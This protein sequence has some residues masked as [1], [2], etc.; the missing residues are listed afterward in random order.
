[1]NKHDKPV[2]SIRARLND[3]TLTDRIEPTMFK[4]P[5][6]VSAI[7]TYEVEAPGDMLP[8]VETFTSL[9]GEGPDCGTPTFFIRLAGCAVGCYKCDTK[10]SW[11]I[12]GKESYTIDSIMELAMNAVEVHRVPRISVTGG[13]PLHW[14]RTAQL[15]KTLAEERYDL[16]YQINLETSGLIFDHV[17]MQYADSISLDVK[18]P[19]Y[20]V[21]DTTEITLDVIGTFLKQRGLFQFARKE[22]VQPRQKLGLKFVIFNPD[23]LAFAN[24]FLARLRADYDGRHLAEMVER[25][26]FT[27]SLTPTEDGLYA[28]GTDRGQSIVE[29]IKPLL[30][31]LG[32]FAVQ[33]PLFVRPQMHK[34]LNIR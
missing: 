5:K 16:Y 24:E 9:E 10:E 2:E 22:F 31:T 11:R 25:G 8:I 15:M 21:G 14:L 18:T 3:Y 6:L 20:R 30:E 13:E 4:T 23:D 17:S 27:I 34:S 12:K 33:P 28:R 29:E 32:K 1:M 19:G 7:T 26:E